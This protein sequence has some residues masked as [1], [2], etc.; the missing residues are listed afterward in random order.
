MNG[1]PALI[2]LHSK[3]QEHEK[4]LGHEKAAES[5]FGSE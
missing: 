4:M 1:L 5:E 2:G 3:E